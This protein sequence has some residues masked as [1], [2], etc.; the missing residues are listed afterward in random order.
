[1]SEAETSNNEPRLKSLDTDRDRSQHLNPGYSVFVKRMRFVLPVIILGIFAL[2]L[3]W[4]QMENSFIEAPATQPQIGNLTESDAV[5]AVT[6]NT[7]VAPR[8]ESQDS[9][10]QPFVITADLA[11][12]AKQDENLVF[13]TQPDGDLSLTSGDTLKIKAVEGIYHQKKG[14]LQLKGD[15]NITH[16]KGYTLSTESLFINITKAS[17]NT[18]NAVVIDGQAGRVEAPSMNISEDAMIVTFPGPA[19]AIIKETN[20]D[21]L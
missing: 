15:V 1:M 17:A 4:P 14:F 10:N 12:Q 6:Q 13:L 19:K 16:G 5:N 21:L 2:L 18:N 7:M 9:N 8:F 3:I 20:S 11:E